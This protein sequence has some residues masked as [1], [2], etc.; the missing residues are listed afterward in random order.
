M[1]EV[2]RARDTKLGRDVAIK[3]LPEEFTR[4][5]ERL[6][7]FD[8]E[9][10]LLAALN[11]PHIAS[12]YGLE[13]S[14]GQK[15]LVMELAEGETLAELMDRGPIAVE[16]A[17]AIAKQVADALEAAHEKG[18]IHRDLKPGNIVVDAD[19]NVRVLDFGLAKAL[20]IDEASDSD[21]TNSPTMVRAATGAGVILGTAAY[22]SPEQAR[23]KRVDRRADIWAFGVVLWEMLSGRRLFRG[24]TVSDT[25]A[26]VLRADVDLAALPAATP[27][28][29]RWLLSRCLQ[30]D[31]RKRLRDIG[32]ARVLLESPID[33][34][35]PAVGEGSAI[36]GRAS[37]LPWIV[38]ALILGALLAVSGTTF[39]GTGTNVQP[40]ME[41]SLDTT[42]A[43]GV[44]LG[45]SLDVPGI[46]ISPDGRVIAF[47]GALDEPGEGGSNKRL[48][49]VRSLDRREATP[50]QGTEN[51]NRPFFMA[52]G[53]SIAFF[54]GGDLY[55]VDVGGGPVRQIA[56]A[57][58][59]IIDASSASENTILAVVRNADRTE[60][61]F[62]RIRDDGASVET[63]ALVTEDRGG[64]G[65]PLF[66]PGERAIIYLSY[67]D[68]SIQVLDLE[69]GKRSLLAHG[70]PGGWSPTGHLLY[71]NDGQIFALPF[72][73]KKLE[74]TGSA[75]PVRTGLS[76]G[77]LYSNSH[78]AV[79]EN[80]TLVSVSQDAINPMTDTI[81]W[82]KPDGSTS[83][84]GAPPSYYVDPRIS[85]DGRFLAVSVPTIGNDVWVH[86]LER[87]SRTRL[88]FGEKEDETPI[89]S[90]DSASVAWASSGPDGRSVLR[91]N[92][93]GSGAE[94]TLWTDKRHF[95][96]AAWSPDGSTIIIELRD[97]TTGN[98]VYA[99][100][101]S[102]GTVTPLLN[103]PYDE[104]L[105]RLSPDGRW[106]VYTSNETKAYEVYM[107]PY[108]SLDRKF[109]LSVD[110]GGQPVWS[111]D[112]R[113][114]FY[115]NESVVLAVDVDTSG[116]EPRIS[117]P[118][119]ALDQPIGFGK[120]TAHWGY[121]V[122][123]DGRFLVTP[124]ESK[125]FPRRLDIVV[126]W[127][128][129]LVSLTSGRD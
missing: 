50:L 72:D 70:I 58:L 40:T 114:L 74:A 53:K 85:P 39:L 54:K 11:H 129:E 29:I 118:R 61:S 20:D 23:G 93:D 102:D 94:T 44:D 15:F 16:D 3:V 38:G 10:R 46:A 109:Q 8:R 116:S 101:I 64:T 26:A 125:F 108:P 45:Q 49:F 35:V 52:D 88:S 75:V 98:D 100:H 27:S 103:A 57:S 9:A 123:A 89:W 37:M 105:P 5:T 113:T 126:G 90:P 84:L 76:T 115:R 91:R 2:W 97:P 78:F 73:R 66:V 28:N 60:R 87:G 121:D 71:T 120:G 41:L 43:L 33:E 112:G 104:I 30:R 107:Q 77:V 79:S 67:S 68:R 86:D 19:G 4:D 62:V 69:T 21:I 14:D 119:T 117:K 95:H 48:L 36:A 56:L 22:M 13:E 6:A 25:L 128:N 106:L 99:L 81:L 65:R 17:I 122:A 63:L 12:I 7:R 24:E 1:G 110:G 124:P 42:P 111:H 31:P 51:V 18:I 34:A 32:E 47:T 92:R 127:S 82:M 59:D 80:G 83:P 96:C 55:R